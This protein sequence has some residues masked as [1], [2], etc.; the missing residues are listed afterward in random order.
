MLE[1]LGSSRAGQFPW[2]VSSFPFFSVG[3]SRGFVL[4]AKVGVRPVLRICLAARLL[5]WCRRAH[6]A[7]MD[8]TS[9]YIVSLH[10]IS[11]MNYPWLFFLSGC[12]LVL[13][14]YGFILNLEGNHTPWKWKNPQPYGRTFF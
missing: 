4:T 14:T 3:L 2:R 13:H 11:P 12:P 9:R 7:D 10:F 6:D 1:K 8:I 5:G